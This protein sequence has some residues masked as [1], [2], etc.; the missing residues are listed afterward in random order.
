MAELPKVGI[1]EHTLFA[2]AFAAIVRPLLT[3]AAALATTGHFRSK[4]RGCGSVAS[5]TSNPSRFHAASLNLLRS[6]TILVCGLLVLV[7]SSTGAWALENKTEA[8]TMTLSGSEVVVLS[9]ASASGGKYVAYFTN[10][11][12]QAVFNGAATGVTLRARGTTCKRTP[13]SLDVYVD[14]SHK[15]TARAKESSSFTD[16]TLALPGVGDGAHTLRVAFEND[17]FS[18]KCDRNAY[19]DYASLTFTDAGAVTPADG[20]EYSPMPT[21][22]TPTLQSRIDNATVGSTITLPDDCAFR[23]AV[24]IGK[25]LTISGG[26]IRGSDVWT[27]WSQ[28]GDNFVSAQSVPT[29]GTDLEGIRCEPNTTDCLM[30]EQVFV[31]G[32]YVDQIANGADPG[33]GQFSMH[34]NRRIVLGFNPA[35]KVVEVTVRKQWLKLLSSDITVD[36]LEARH[37]G[38][39]A[40][41]HAALISERANNVVKNSEL[42]Y[43]HGDLLGM[44][45]QLNQVAVGNDLHHGGHSGWAAYKGNPDLINNKIHH[46]NIEKYD[47]NWSGGGTKGADLSSGSLW[48]GNELYENYGNALWCD[49]YCDGVIIENNRIH[50]NQGG[51]I[52]Y[53]ISSNG[54]IRNNTIWENG[55]PNEAGG[56]SATL[57]TT[58]STNV[59]IYGNVVAWNKTGISA[60]KSDRTSDPNLPPDMY[61]INIHDNVVMLE[62]VNTVTSFNSCHRSLGMAWC[63]TVA[64]F[65]FFDPA[66]NN[67]AVNNRYYFTFPEE[68]T[69]PRWFIPNIGYATIGAWNNSPGEEGA[70]Y[71]TQ[72]EKDALIATH[73]LPTSPER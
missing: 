62:R 12:A 45:Q 25:P 14:G 52:F 60:V 13:A 28:S 32:Q 55:W 56:W 73:N 11:S 4:S 46:N 47:P 7:L 37:A 42:S 67:R 30:K 40:T 27:S 35:G 43:A 26:H 39:G 2:A 19:L 72:A 68:S 10:G 70:R 38:N 33:P 58:S 18:R 48:A 8:E 66:K 21:C 54:I 69:W 41:Y 59:E 50:H 34:A 44:H 5:V 17:Y 57:K 49:V 16:Y 15:A 51:G 63:N 3:D 71:L 31:D 24:T 22:A 23:E 61:N 53:E 9:S 6:L 20:G 36:S 1:I 65:N 29:L 64:G